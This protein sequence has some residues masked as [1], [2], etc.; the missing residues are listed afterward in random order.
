MGLGLASSFGET[1]SVCTSRIRL[2][3][4]DADTT[5]ESA[6]LPTNDPSDIAL[7]LH[8]SGTTSRPK[9]VPLSQ[10]NLASSV[11]NIKSVYKLTES[12][13]T[14]IVLPLVHVHGLLAGLLSSPISGAAVALLAAREV[15]CLNL[16][17]RHDQVQRYMVYS[18]PDYPS[19]HPLSGAAAPL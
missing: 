10:L 4:A 5:K 17:G 11:Q 2:S 9:G 1:V 8:T 18:R 19:N 6:S 14:V 7:F 13:S 16:L 12:D 15:L 3:S